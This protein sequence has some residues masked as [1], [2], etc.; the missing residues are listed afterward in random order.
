M[1][2]SPLGTL[3]HSPDRVVS[4]R[5]IDANR[6]NAS[7][8]TG[9]RT[10]EGKARVARNA[11]K[12]GFFADTARWTPHQQSQF[13]Q[14][15][16]GLRADL[17]PRGATEESCVA[18]MA[19][20]YVK[21]G[22]LLRFEALAAFKSHQRREREFEAKIATS[23]RAVA[24]RLISE[25]EHLQRDGLWG[26][27]IP[28][29]R[30]MRAILRYEGR[31]NRLIASA[32]GTLRE[33]REGGDAFAKLQKQTHLEVSPSTALRPGERLRTALLARYESAKT[34][35][36]GGIADQ[37][38]EAA[39][40]PRSALLA[41]HESAKTNPNNPAFTGNRHERRKMKALQRRALRS[42]S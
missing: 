21:M 7:R 9:P 10:A 16:Q 28:D 35:P 4:Q 3:P 41:E 42:T 18:T 27:T 13:D 8:S 37:C 5:S 11:I 24:E 22:M 1:S 19:T 6:R 2:A 34:N 17:Q 40:G 15:L 26:P 33:A 29:E 12:H 38:P 39:E 32:Y 14:T 30:E 36:L 31:L 25:R 23:N 20:S